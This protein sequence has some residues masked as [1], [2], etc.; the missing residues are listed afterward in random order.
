MNRDQTNNKFN[1]LL[2]TYKKAN[3][4]LFLKTSA[5]ILFIWFLRKSLRQH[6]HK[7]QNGFLTFSLQFV[8]YFSMFI[9]TVGPCTVIGPMFYTIIDIIF[10]FDTITQ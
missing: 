7:I 1:F 10:R 8:P 3:S 2:V 9:I 5:D 4:K 6:S